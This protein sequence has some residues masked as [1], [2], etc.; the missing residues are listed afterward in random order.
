MLSSRPTTHNYLLAPL[1]AE[2]HRLASKRCHPRSAVQPVVIRYLNDPA[3]R[4]HRT[5]HRHQN[6]ADAQA[7]QLEELRD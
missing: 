6:L 5:D 4:N 3:S 7:K 1:V 2:Q